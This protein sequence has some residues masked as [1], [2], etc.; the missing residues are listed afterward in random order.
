MPF[1][2]SRSHDVDDLVGMLKSVTG[3][4]AEPQDVH[5]AW[6]KHSDSVCAGWM[7]FDP[8]D[9]DDRHEIRRAYDSLMEERFEALVADKV[10]EHDHDLVLDYV[11]ERGSDRYDDRDDLIEVIDVATDEKLATYA[12]YSSLHQ[13]LTTDL[14]MR[15]DV[16]M[17]EG[18]DIGV[19]QVLRAFGLKTTY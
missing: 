18:S 15:F 17:P 10:P 14:L 4:Q 9:D 3:H 2:S 8:V 6:Q 11:R 16:D 7:S 13:T 5:D 12:A 1:D 19:D